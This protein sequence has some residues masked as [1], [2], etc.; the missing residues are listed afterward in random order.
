MCWNRPVRM[1]HV[2]RACPGSAGGLRS[3]LEMARTRRQIE[4]RIERIKGEVVKLD[5]IHPGSLSKQYNVCGHAQCRCKADPP[6]RHGPYHQVSFT[7]RGKNT[8]RFVRKADLAR[9]TRELRNYERLR[10][11]TDEWVE[12]SM[13]LTKLDKA[14]DAA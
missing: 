9:V 3:R 8:S 11:L 6:Q 5:R 1:L 2:T 14:D 7:W 10:E 13:E 12:L 4:A